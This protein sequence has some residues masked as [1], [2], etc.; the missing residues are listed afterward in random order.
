MAEVEQPPRDSGSASRVVSPS[1]EDLD[2]LRTPLERGERRVFDFFDQHLGPE[3][4]IYVQPHLNNLRPDLVLLN[5]S[6]GIAVFEVKDL[7]LAACDWRV[8]QRDGR[9]CLVGTNTSGRRFRKPNPFDRLHQYR[10]EIA[11]LYCPTLNRR[12]GLACVTAGLIVPFADEDELVDRF[13][14]GWRHR[15]PEAATQ[16]YL[17]LSGAGALAEGQIDRVFPDHARRRSRQMTIEIADDLR[18]WLVEP[19]FS[20]EQ[21]QRPSLDAEQR[22]LVSTRT[23]TGFRRLRGP[24]GSG[25]TMVVAGRAAT[26]ASEGKDVLVVSYNVTLLNY[27]RDWVAR[28][29]CDTNR[30]TWLNFHAWCKRLL[31][32]AGMSDAYSQLPWREARQDV[33]ED[34]LP[35][36]AINAIETQPDLVGRPD[37]ILVDEGQDFHPNWWATLRRALATGGEMLLV[38]DR[39][40]DVYDRN[41]LW[42]EQAMEGAGFNGPWTTLDRSYRM[43]RRLAELTAAFVE[44]YLSDHDITP[45]VPADQLEIDQTRL[46]WVQTEKNEL[47]AASVEAIRQSLATQ[48]ANGRA[49]TAFADIVFLCHRKDLG[50]EVVSRL[51]ALGVHVIDTFSSN[52]Q[53]ERRQ[54]RYFFKGD[55]RVKATTIHSFKGW[56][57]RHLIVAAGGAGGQPAL[58]AVYA[59]L[60]RLKA[61]VSGS[62]LTVVCAAPELESFGKTWP[63]FER[64]RR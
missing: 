11:E 42:T 23:D 35:R 43:P 58:S 1:R 59:G 53:E 39:A 17:T 64:L 51:S 63:E 54:K 5:P 21:R 55:A 24:A 37:A 25:K 14:I 62:H 45:P 41:R 7:D 16:R 29:D 10:T 6:V 15:A 8:E 9:P 44:R 32:E 61:H 12:A 27:I 56:E 49:P 50:R 40:Q 31:F 22:R 36:A 26:L 46:C 19:D 2:R 3:W 18:H 28:F 57:G 52:S 13:G 47:A 20:A 33:L 60:T 38:A 4:E 48:S 34:L 30:I